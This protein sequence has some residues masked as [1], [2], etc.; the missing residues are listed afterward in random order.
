[1]RARIMDFEQ[2]EGTFQTPQHMQ[3]KEKRGVFGPNSMFETGSVVF[4]HPLLIRIMR[5]APAEGGHEF[6]SAGDSLTHGKQGKA[7]RKKS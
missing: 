6:K 5:P 4:H 7:A 2:V 3:V 1:M